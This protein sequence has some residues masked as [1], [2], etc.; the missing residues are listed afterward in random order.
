[1]KKVNKVMKKPSRTDRLAENTFHQFNSLS[2]VDVTRVKMATE[3]EIEQFNDRIE[4]LSTKL[5]HLRVD[6]AENL[7]V[8][9]GLNRIL[10]ARR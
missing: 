2:S 9:E 4:E 3:F 8:R 10:Q 5:R 7:A 1:M 6:L